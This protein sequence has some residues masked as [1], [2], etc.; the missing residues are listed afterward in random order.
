MS[1]GIFFGNR[2]IILP[3]AYARVNVEA[4]TAPR[5]VPSRAI[6]IVATAEGGEVGGVT[7]VN[8]LE[9]I[10][11]RLIGGVGAHM[12]ELAMAPSG[13]VVGVSD[14]HFV[15]VN[16]AVPATLALGNA[17]LSAHPAGRIG[18]G[19]SVRRVITGDSTDLHLRHLA[20]GIEE[21][22]LG[23]G[24]VLRINHVGA[25]ALPTVVTTTAA[26]VT[27]LTLTSTTVSVFSSNNLVGL[28]DLVTAINST[29]EWTASLIGPL[30]GVRFDQLDI[31]SF[32][33]TAGSTQL[34]IGGQ[35]LVM[36]LADSRLARAE[37]TAG[38]A[39]ALTT[40]TFMAGGSEGP[41]PT[42]ANWTEAIG[43]LAE[44][45]LHS[46]VV[47]TGDLA[48]LSAARAHVETSSDAKNRRE[49]FLYC[50]PARSA[51]RTALLDSLR[52]MA[53][54]L[55]SSRVR[56]Y[57]SEPQLINALTNRLEVFPAFYL[58]AMA[59]GMKAGNRPEMPLTNKQVAIFGLSYN[60]SVAELED[61]ARLGVATAHFDAPT[62]NYVITWGITSYTRDANVV[63]RK[64]AGMDIADYL[65]K[66]IRLRLRRYIGEVGDQFTIAQ[67]RD[68]V[69]SMLSTEVRGADNRDGVLTDGLDPQTGEYRPGFRNVEVIM[70]G[71]DLVAI[72]YEANPVGEIAYITA[73]AYLRPV[74][75]VA[76]A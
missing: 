62:G 6:G 37:A 2:E 41:V 48:V 20:L 10:R 74:R 5:G 33:L 70:D 26:G 13:Q 12:A 66:L 72:R 3:G 73:T 22:Y 14:I 36:A 53:P 4:M 67:I 50:G 39:T 8:S 71:F 23:L 24:P 21:S 54:G 9:D 55:S 44:I 68:V 11:T 59:A 31:R 49:R 69:V 35:A 1:I 34:T 40:W 19:V 51:S 61:M 18:N 32:T 43:R 27:T 7:R 56:I 17:T 38:T 75:I 15:R 16:A 52:A 60:L 76:S 29:A 47:G 25:F 58:A 45:E 46:I 64:D 30:R 42:T 63:L 57:G 28:D 65:N